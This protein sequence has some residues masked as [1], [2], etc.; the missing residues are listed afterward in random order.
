[1]IQS[2]ILIDPQEERIDWVNVKT[3][4][5]RDTAEASIHARLGNHIDSPD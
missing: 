4:N 2:G 3:M 5:V 1:M